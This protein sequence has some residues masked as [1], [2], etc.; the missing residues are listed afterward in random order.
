[1]VEEEE[2]GGRRTEGRTEA[3]ERRRQEERI[4]GKEKTRGVV[5]SQGWKQRG[6]YKF[7]VGQLEQVNQEKDPEK[8]LERGVTGGDSPPQPRLPLPPRLLELWS[9]RR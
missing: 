6:R 5:R 8:D 1:M 3:G 7:H 2:E 4:R 9:S